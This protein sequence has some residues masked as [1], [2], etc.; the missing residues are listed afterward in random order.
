VHHHLLVGGVAPAG[1][2]VIIG[3]VL[4]TIIAAAFGWVLAMPALRV[5]GPYLAMV[6]LAFGTIVA[7]LI[8]E[9]TDLTNGP[10]GITLNRPLFVDL[11][12]LA[13]T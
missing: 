4:G 9:V 8:N 6:T 10:L 1:I 12:P 7:I 2:D 13:G 5:T 3:V 11:K